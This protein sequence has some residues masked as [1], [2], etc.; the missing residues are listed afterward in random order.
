MITGSMR[1][2]RLSPQQQRIWRLSS[3]S[4]APSPFRVGGL[5]A[6]D[7]L[8]GAAQLL[9]M[10][11]ALEQRH[12]ILRS[13]F[14]K[15][16]GAHEPLQ[17]VGESR[18]WTDCPSVDWRGRSREEI[19]RAARELLDAEFQ[20][21]LDPADSVMRVSLAQIA[22]S[23]WLVCIVLSA[24]C[25]DAVSLDD[26]AGEL[27]AAAHPS[28]A[29]LQEP[30]LQYADVTDWL[31]SEEER[32]H[33]DEDDFWQDEWRRA[34]GAP[35]SPLTSRFLPGF[36]RRTLPDVVDPED[37]G[38]R[39]AIF[40]IWT[41]IIWRRLQE[42]QGPV[43]MAV[44]ADR[45]GA[46]LGGALG[47]FA[48]QLPVS[49]SIDPLARFGDWSATANVHW[50]EVCRHDAGF[51]LLAPDTPRLRWGFAW[52]DR[53]GVATGQGICVSV[54][55]TMAVTETFD[56]ALECVRRPRGWALESVYNRQRFS[57]TEIEQ[58]LDVFEQELRRFTANRWLR[59]CDGAAVGERESAVIVARSSGRSQ[60]VVGPALLH[61][62]VV[63][64]SRRTPSA[65]AVEFE[66][67][68][69]T[70]AE[71]DGISDRIARMLSSHGVGPEHVVAVW[72]ERSLEFPV[73]LVAVLKAGAAFLAMDSDLPPD[74]LVTIVEEARPTVLLV[75][76]RRVSAMPPLPCRLLPYAIAQPGTDDL[77]EADAAGER[78][79]IAPENLAY[80]IYTSGSTGT[81]KGAMV[82][83]RAIV[84]QMEWIQREWP[85]G[86]GAAV[87]LKTSC[88]FD[89]F[90]WEVF[91]P[92]VNGGRVVVARPGGQH[93]P[94]YLCQ[95]MADR[96]VE[97]TYFVP[98]MLRSLLAEPGIR[99][100]TSLG[101]IPAGGE[102]VPLEVIRAF[103]QAVSGEFLH[104]YGPAEAAIAV[105]GCI[106]PPDMPR[107]FAP[108][109]E[110]VMNSR[111]Y[112]LDEYLQLTPDGAIGEI[113]IAGA[114]LGR[115]YV[116][117]AART[118]LSFVP[119]P[120]AE[121]PGG[122]MYR[123]GDLA[124]RHADGAI[125]FVGR[126]DRQVK[127]HG[128]RVELSEIEFHLNSLSNVRQ[129]AVLAEKGVGGEKHLVAYVVTNDGLVD[130]TVVRR[131][132]QQKLPAYMVPAEIVFLDAMPL[133]V[134]GKLD[135]RR[136]P[137]LA[138]Q[139]RTSAVGA[140]PMSPAEQLVA[141][142]WSKVLHVEQVAADSDFFILG[143]HSLLA[144]Q[145]A[146]RIERVLDVQLPLRLMLDLTTVALF[147]PVLECLVAA[148]LLDAPAAETL[149]ALDE[150]A[151]DPRTGPPGMAALSKEERVAV[152][153]R[154]LRAL[155]GAAPAL[156][157]RPRTEARLSTAQRRMWFLERVEPNTAVFN[158][159]IALRYRG[160]LSV[161]RLTQALGRLVER[162]ETL[163]STFG[164]RE[165]EPFQRIHAPHEVRIEVIDCGDA[166][167]VRRLRL[168][169]WRPFDLESSPPIRA[170][171]L[172]T[173]HT[174]GVL[175]LLLH[176]IVCDDWSMGVLTRDLVAFYDGQ[177]DRLPPL[178][179]QYADVAEWEADQLAGAETA[180]SLLWWR[181]HLRN[182]PVDSLPPRGTALAGGLRAIAVRPELAA[183]LVEVGRR[184]RATLFMLLRA[185]IDALVYC[186]WET[187]DIV[188]GSPF[189][190]RERPETSDLIGLLLNPLAIR[191]RV[192]PDATLGELVDGARAAILAAYE[193]RQVPFEA[194]LSARDDPRSRNPFSVWL[195]VQNA[196][197]P[198]LRVA[199]LEIETLL[200]E[201]DVPK[202]GLSLLMSQQSF[203]G[204]FEYRQDVFAERIDAIAGFWQHILERLTTSP[205]MRLTE[206]R[207]AWL[208]FE[209][210]TSRERSQTALK[211]FRAKADRAF[212]RVRE[213]SAER[214]LSPGGR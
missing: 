97:S 31:L 27:A 196:P 26:L 212:E 157:R 56:L 159:P 211:D 132:L 193:H 64:Q 175:L 207:A 6:I 101:R 79:P 173:S 48:K 111:V 203:E 41:L 205:E 2:F 21:P 1:G 127:I 9:S 76:E 131:E 103:Y 99:E 142:T 3:D 13:R 174:D 197:A 113:C 168:E 153:R 158:V 164:E 85:L 57:E 46:S 29:E 179:I 38:V 39:E 90:I 100:V 88:G 201:P 94:A 62:A 195:S 117:L 47:A 140:S 20:A 186:L 213:G 119:D 84:N 200:V 198:A 139:P 110:P 116:H 34:A 188:I 72:G 122:R 118:A 171:L 82:S 43:V 214:P 12:E 143:G 75:P 92:L 81:P 16:S 180:E 35:Q 106:V 151:D 87:L 182:L 128:S 15:P 133:S 53:A 189:A 162:H 32:E 36:V 78:V 112:L 63:A 165:G 54:R 148:S 120:F 194:V 160:E 55:E 155:R 61:D 98:S 192:R 5:L 71:L 33:D 83:H 45:R 102:A 42:R 22:D 77:S 114:A 37:P 169:A 209:R 104:L 50:R 96:S 181:E 124:R 176:H 25:A 166:D 109:G 136:L 152:N 89:P 66:D 73:A 199:G 154:I 156:Q 206:L 135:R 126:V 208:E 184:R 80:V 4:G 147:A 51:R 137:E 7:G 11:E 40:A 204:F 172:R 107:A 177:G 115:G 125:E 183:Q 138:R 185:A 146:A 202:F 141:D 23:S 190:N 134:N 8:E 191:T 163:R 52:T 28:D 58:V 187:T 95:L 105:L 67:Q 17:V 108:L 59:L 69:L 44:R 70:Y 68:S 129:G 167:L 30:A 60:D 210:Q 121:E 18:P 130:A 123:T 144:A 161:E 65:T 10:L 150:Y 170:A 86:D 49:V 91:W 14:I 93:Q 178:A 19:D 24:L 149:R 74:R 145:V